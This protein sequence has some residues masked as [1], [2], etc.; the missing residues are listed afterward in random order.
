M[1]RLRAAA[2]AITMAASSLVAVSAA[3]PAS[4]ARAPLA[5]VVVVEGKACAKVGTK[6]S[7]RSTQYV[8]T[9]SGSKA[10]WRVN[11]ATVKAG[12]GCTKVAE[13][14]EVGPRKALFS[15]TRGAN[16]ALVWR[17]ASKECK[18][19][20][21]LYNEVR[22]QFATVMSQVSALESANAS[23]SAAAAAARAAANAAGPEGAAAAAAAAE[24]EATAASS[25]I[26]LASMKASITTMGGWS[27]DL[28]ESI[29]LAC[30]GLG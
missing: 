20:V 18:S 4:A 26:A 28:K 3:A 25:R 9:K 1:T 27:E 22:K 24:A 15:C 17:T 7:V 21:A 30:G 14:A 5:K 12:R 13:L 23:A 19:A 6:A 16:K 2:L 11:A 10:V 8:C 29:P